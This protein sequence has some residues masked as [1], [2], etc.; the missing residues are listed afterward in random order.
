[1]GPLAEPAGYHAGE[2]PFTIVRPPGTLGHAD[3]LAGYLVFVVFCA[4]ALERQ[5]PLR[6][7][8]AVASGTAALAAAGVLLSGT[9]AA[10]AGLAAGGLLLFILDGRHVGRKQIAAAAAVLVL[11]A[12]FVLSPAGAKLRARV[13]WS[14][15][16]PFGGARLP[17]WRDTLRMAASHPWLGVGPEAFVLEFPRSNRSSWHAP[18]RT[19][20]TS[21]RTTLCWT[22][23]R[24]KASRARFLSWR[25][26]ESRGSRVSERGRLGRPGRL[27]C[28]HVRPPCW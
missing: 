21:R 20:T 24:R 18:T 12:A 22:H 25:P 27:R 5:E 17:L 16:D 19:S 28:C 13:H 23:W 7:M 26:G 3:Y 2:G 9:R 15:D 8:R 4:L 10:L 1:M 11:L 6:W 14:A